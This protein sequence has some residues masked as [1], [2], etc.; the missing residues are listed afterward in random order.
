MVPR[1]ENR[2]H[3]L[4]LLYHDHDDGDDEDY[5][6]DYDQHDDGDYEDDHDD[7]IMKRRRTCGE[8]V[9][10]LTFFVHGN[11]L[12]INSRGISKLKLIKSQL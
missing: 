2:V 3:L 6:D 1:G 7:M 9:V 8:K 4:H 5:E 12:Q 11:V 10:S